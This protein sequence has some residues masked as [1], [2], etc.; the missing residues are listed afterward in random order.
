M[1][2]AHLKQDENYRF[3]WGRPRRQDK[4]NQEPSK[5]EQLKAWR[6]EVAKDIMTTTRGGL[7]E[8]KRTC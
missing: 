5:R 4:R 3:V 2:V 7:V 8:E 6:G 1:E